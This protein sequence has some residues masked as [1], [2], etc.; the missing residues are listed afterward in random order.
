MKPICLLPIRFCSVMLMPL[1]VVVIGSAAAAEPRVYR[2]GDTYSQTPCGDNA[3]QPKLYGTGAD[4]T[5]AMQKATSCAAA[6]ASSRQE[7]GMDWH[8]QEA[9]EPKAE[10]INAHGSQV[11]GFRLTVTMVQ[12]SA[13]GQRVQS[14]RFRCDVSQDFQR[15]LAVQALP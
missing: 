2:C 3:S 15:V 8:L 5:D 10:L 1:V 12:T 4:T 9:S 7:E 6:I 14:G 13:Q 11:V